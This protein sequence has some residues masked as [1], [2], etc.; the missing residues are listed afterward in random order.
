MTG[1]HT[2]PA[3]APRPGRAAPADPV[4]LLRRTA[5]RLEREAQALSR[6]VPFGLRAVQRALRRQAASYAGAARVPR[7]LADQAAQL[8]GDARRTTW[9]SMGTFS[10]TEVT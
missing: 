1:C 4:R 5:G 3:D 2:P 9:V 6:P 7:A 10:P 8:S